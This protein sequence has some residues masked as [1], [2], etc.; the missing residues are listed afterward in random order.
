MDPLIDIGYIFLKPRTWSCA[1]STAPS[2]EF[3]PF[4][5]FRLSRTFLMLRLVGDVG[6]DPVL[7]RRRYFGATSPEIS[8]VNLRYL[9]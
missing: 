5:T 7:G 8:P 9:T 2:P 6:D 4:C 3:R 1:P